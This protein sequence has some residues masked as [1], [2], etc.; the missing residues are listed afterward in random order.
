MKAKMSLNSLVRIL[1]KWNVQ[2][3]IVLAA[4][5]T[6]MC[7]SNAL[8]QSGAGAI[9]GTVTDSSGAVI[10]GA[11]IHVVNQANGVAADTKSNDVGFY[12]VPGLFTGTYSVTISAP[13]MKSYKS[14]IELLVDQ[15][16]IINATMTAGDVTQQVE[17]S[18]NVVQLTTTDNGTIASTLEN[19]RLNQLPMN[20]RFLLS[21]ADETTPGLE[22]GGQRANGLMPSAL[23]YV[24]DGVTLS[25]RNL[26]GEGQLGSFP[27]QLPDPDA[28]QEVRVETTN[29]SAQFSEPATGIITTKSGTNGL[30]GSF[31]E[32]A[33]NSGVGIAKGRQD[34]SNFSEPHLVRNE[35]GA[36]AG[37]PIILPHVYHGKN[38]S[39]WFFAY[40]RYSLASESDELV[41]VPTVAMRQGDFSGLISS[42]GILQA[43]Y[44]PSTTAP[45]ANC[46]TNTGATESNA[47]CRTQFAY[48]GIPN[49][50]N[51]ARIS[52]MTKVL[53]DIIPLPT[54]AANPLVAPNLTTP[55]IND[56]H[57]P[58]VTFRL[59][60]SF[61]EKNN[62][63][64]RYTDNILS[65]TT[66]QNNPVNTPATIAGGGLPAGASGLQTS[67]TAMF[68]AALG[69][70]HVFSPTFFSE[71]ILSQQWYNQ[72]YNAGPNA[73]LDYEKTLGLPNN[74][75]EAGFPC[76]AGCNYDWSIM[77]INGTQFVFKESQIISD[78]DENLTKT[79]G[80]HQMQFGGRYRHE[81][82]DY[83]P[84]R[85]QDEVDFTNEGT[86]LELPSSGAN[87]ATSPNTGYPDGDLFLGDA[88]NYTVNLEPPNVHYH[89][90]EF[91]AYFQDN[92]HVTKNLTANLGLRYEAHPGAWT[93][94]G[95]TEGFD[96]KNDAQV[97][98]NPVSYYIAKGYTTQAIITN[99]QNLG[100]IFESPQEAGY[101]S[102]MIDNYDFNFG[103]RVG[104]A[105]QP[106]GGKHGTV[107]RGAYGRYIYPVPVRNS[108]RNT[109]SS[110]P[111]VASYSQNYVNA[112][113]SP[114]GL[115]NYLA[116]APQSVIAGLNSSDVVNSG[117]TN[118]ILPGQGLWN[119]DPKYPPSFVTQMNFT[120]EQSLRGNSALRLSWLYT[121]GANL[122]H[123]YF[124]NNQPSTYV[125]EMA[126][127]IVP[128]TGTVVGSNQYAA[129]AT[130]PYDQT[131]YGDSVWDAANGWSN[132][133]ALQATYQRLFH[134]GIAYQINYV[135][136]KPFRV[137]GNYFRDSQAFP[138][139]NFQ[140]VLGSAG[141]MTSPYGQVV[142]PNPLPAIPTG[143]PVWAEY[144]ALDRYENYI[145]DTAVPKQ[146]IT[147]NGII[148][149]PAGRG[150]RF[151][152][153]ANRFEDEIVGGWQIAGDGG[154]VSQDF[155]VNA[156]NW[157]PTNP[158]KIYKH[159]APITD[160]RSGVCSKS[161]LWF[162]GYIPPTA[163]SGNSCATASQTV[164]GLPTAYQP[165]Q[166]PIDNSCTTANFGTNNVQ[167][168]AP[169]LNGGVP[170][171]VQYA[172]GP[173]SKTAGG[174]NPY[175]HTVLN[176]PM[177][178]TTDFSVFK[179]FPITEKVN[180]RFNVD[181]FNAFNVQGFNNPDR[182]DGTEAV[183]PNGVS[184]SYNTPRQLQFT[185]RLT[186]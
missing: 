183:E 50:I 107:V 18:A 23:E 71:T 55:G 27:P 74:F 145:V 24:A 150:K 147:F 134:H 68:S 152:S 96:L 139:A 130:G 108:I 117:T 54:S 21:L 46:V 182:T 80:R 135:W 51:P 168:T 9:Q 100:V 13:G 77:P 43:L 20:G 178:W 111:F 160:C 118:S 48:N 76:I 132:D 69:F 131:K 62:A 177:N 28:V 56:A 19:D 52:P 104:L 35:F 66:L 176:G 61:N 15:A 94:D 102:T 170:V 10:P 125:W 31:F 163:I 174:V 148:D 83:L 113:Q 109:T 186:F 157:G 8:A 73:N 37:G 162:N 126:Y 67:P 173:S 115:P 166:T 82:F 143:T 154:V 79:V 167:V 95:L 149:V 47:Y 75:G 165:Y 57:V 59:D 32:T 5:G 112:S 106:F 129:T 42:A 185:A 138:A 12:Q 39:F 78:I 128:P 89:D 97:L 180:L 53:M 93:K 144:H 179:V 38:K 84:D 87:Y 3:F 101:P 120:V 64:L 171:T 7:C 2:V 6:A 103:P 41:T 86:G 25:N 26:G 65:A 172:P 34:P 161:Y 116:R 175:S 122:D 121:H 40:E 70:T 4:L 136:S 81:R 164:A 92:F 72:F 181:A 114:D 58:T 14:V 153:N 156:T 98:T 30:H 91:D 155:T 146:H 123:Y 85:L 124:Y 158:I 11:S 169:T 140:G 159:S 29:T 142:A 105:Y 22:D 184:S 99:L 141:T 133:N 17:V 16:A 90:M 63:Y 1:C 88:A 44:D 137:G 49:V 119:L 33:R 110:L 127:G 60:H 36:S 45:S 151:L